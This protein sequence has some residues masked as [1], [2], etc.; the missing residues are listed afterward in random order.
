M[1]K[2]YTSIPLSARIFL[3]RRISLS[4]DFIVSFCALMIRMSWAFFSFNESSS[5]SF[6]RSEPVVMF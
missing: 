5:R 6:A 2:Y 1:F 3:K 4:L